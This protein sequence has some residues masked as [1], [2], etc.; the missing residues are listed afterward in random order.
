M[1]TL[2]V[3]TKNRLNP[4]Y[5]AARNAADDVAR[6]G[7]ARAVHF[8]PE[9]PDDILQ[10]KELVEEALKLGPDAVVFVPVDDVAMEPDLAKFAAAGIP[11]VTCINRIK[12]EVV[13][14][15]G[16]DDVEVG[17]MSAAA[18]FT[19]LGGNG[20]VVAIDGPPAAPT[21]RDRADGVRRALAGFPGIRLLGTACGMN[22]RL[23]GRTAMASLLSL[24][25]KLDGVWCAND[26]MAYGALE[27]LDAARRRAQVVGVNGLDEA[28][29][30]VESGR[31]LATVDFSAFKICRFASEAALRHL[32]GDRV[33]REIM[34]PTSLIDRSNVA[35]WKVPVEQRPS[36]PWEE[37]VG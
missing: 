28:I 36:P 4:A 35:A 27:A 9:K 3:F 18:L 20:K 21:C 5:A 14:H 1:T 2:A 23:E 31:M 12:G 26:V 24:H 25:P 11:V 37:V 7:G 34:V 6:R 30:N 19:G 32:R 33:P 8:V 29:A 13:S 16:S 17:R 22:L 15:V 10:Q